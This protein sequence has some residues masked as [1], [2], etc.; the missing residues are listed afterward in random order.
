[1][2]HPHPAPPHD[3][4]WLTEDPAEKLV[5][6][7]ALVW[8]RAELP[9]PQ[10][11]LYLEYVSIVKNLL[12][13]VGDLTRTE[14]IVRAVLEQAVALEKNS[15]WVEVELRFEAMVSL[16]FIDRDEFIRL[17]L[18]GMA[19]MGDTDLD[20]VFDRFNERTHRFTPIHP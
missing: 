17:E 9:S 20:S 14:T 7:L 19:S 13:D 12:I 1:M 5:R 6:E 3:A 2:T 4:V 16:A 15:T 10:P 11:Y 8:T 18:R